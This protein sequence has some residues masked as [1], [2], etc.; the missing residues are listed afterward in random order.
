MEAR[1]DDG[2]VEAFSVQD[3]AGFTLAMQW[4]PEWKVTEKS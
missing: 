3:A 4:H 2:L 1:A